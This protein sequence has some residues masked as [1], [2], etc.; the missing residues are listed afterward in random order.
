MP[1]KLD[2]ATCGV[3]LLKMFNI[4]AVSGQKCFQV[5]LAERLQ[6]SP[7]TVKRL[8]DTI[9]S[10][11]GVNLERGTEDRRRWYRVR[12]AWRHSTALNDEEKYNNLNKSG[13]TI[14]ALT[15]AIRK[16]I[17]EVA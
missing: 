5:D 11:I 8:A 13:I 9:E 6:C 16:L 3:K 7:Q 17:E 15:N 10:V 2:D 14:N 4:L 12:G 1:P